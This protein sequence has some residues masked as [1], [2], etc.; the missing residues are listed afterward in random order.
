[1]T[2]V[3]LWHLR[4]LCTADMMSHKV[5]LSTIA[6][7]Q[8]ADGRGNCTPHKNPTPCTIP[9]GRDS[10][11]HSMFAFFTK[12]GRRVLVNMQPPSCTL[13]SQRSLTVAPLWG[14]LFFQSVTTSVYPASFT[15]TLSP[16]FGKGLWPAWKSMYGNLL[17]PRPPIK[18]RSF[19]HRFKTSAQH[20]NA[21]EG[22]KQV[23]LF[24]RV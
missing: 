7:F 10:I 15:H 8:V 21:E 19:E 14:S 16:L 1:M 2:N 22:T 12:S 17:Q 23:I 9:Q 3:L 20:R 5:S 4:H 18:R 6:L 13:T 24:W 11:F